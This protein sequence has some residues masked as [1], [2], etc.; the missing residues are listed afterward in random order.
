MTQLSC[1]DGMPR[2]QKCSGRGLKASLRD[3]LG[4]VDTCLA[5]DAVIAS[6][7]RIFAP[8][9]CVHC[10]GAFMRVRQ[11]QTVCS[12]QCAQAIAESRRL[13]AAAVAARMDRVKTREALAAMKPLAF[14]I[15]KAQRSFNAYV[16]L[17]DISA[18]HGC[19]DCGKPF[20]P[21]RPGG[22]VDAGH[23]LSRGS[24]PHLK[25]DERNVFAQRKNC[26]RPGGATRA[27]FRAGVVA[28]IGLP[29]VEALEADQSVQKY[30]ADD[31]RAIAAAY[32]E[33]AKAMRKKALE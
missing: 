1:H 10:K 4:M 5:T 3:D 20:E 12:I 30:C 2:N 11:L 9:K 8:R 29:A 31:L 22:S 33:R 6:Q 26:N 32:D 19:I 23:Y 14:W 28:R 17:R 21:D 15:A 13:K 24:A 25:F 18:G 7:G 27:D 16:R